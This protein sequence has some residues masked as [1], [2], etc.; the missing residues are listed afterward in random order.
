[1][2]TVK[3]L[4]RLILHANY[5]VEAGRDQTSGPRPA[6]YN[7]IATAVTIAPSVVTERTE[8][9]KTP[10]RFPLN[11]SSGG[12]C[13]YEYFG[14]YHYPIFQTVFFALNYYQLNI[15]LIIII[16]FLLAT[17]RLAKFN[18]QCRYTVLANK[19]I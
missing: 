13:G 15:F 16:P 18:R 1:M 7:V 5:G 11:I 14:P 4:V 19:P 10:M 3:N 6:K 2:L 9:K 17:T 8:F 12:K